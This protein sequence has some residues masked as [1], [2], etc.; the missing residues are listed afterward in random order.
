MEWAELLRRV[1]WESGILMKQLSVYAGP[2]S[3]APCQGPFKFTFGDAGFEWRGTD[4]HE[5]PNSRNGAGNEANYPGVDYMFLHNLFFERLF[6][7]KDAG[8][9]PSNYFFASNIPSVNIMD[10]YDEQTWPFQ[11]NFTASGNGISQDFTFGVDANVNSI[12]NPPGPGQLWT[13]KQ[14]GNVKLFQ[15][16]TSRAQIYSVTS[17][18]APTN[19]LPTKIIYRAGKD[20]TLLPED[21]TKPGFEVKLGADF[22]AFIKRYVCSDGDYGSGLRQNDSTN[23]QQNTNDYESDQMMDMVPLHYVDYPQQNSIVY[24]ADPD[25]ESYND[26]SNQQILLEEVLIKQQ[27]EKEGVFDNISND[28]N[29]RFSVLPNPSNGLFSIYLNKISDD[30]TFNVSIFDSKSQIIKSYN[31]VGVSI[32]QQVDLTQYPKGIYLIKI[33][34]NKGFNEVRKLIIE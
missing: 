1:L 8:N 32:N 10:T 13:V 12:S 5:H 31:L 11:V 16:L 22:T 6:Q 9:L 33:F 29:K 21:G 30:E 15:N 14:P 34:S 28:L 24:P 4:R 19:I 2:I 25:V 20:I 3:Q 7:M 17:P 23:Q 27:K 18:Q 26:L